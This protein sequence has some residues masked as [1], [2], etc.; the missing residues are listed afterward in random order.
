M[1]HRSVALSARAVLDGS[2]VA[3]GVAIMATVIATAAVVL[4]AS[5]VAVALGLN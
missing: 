3:R 2:R 1:R 4:M 5:F